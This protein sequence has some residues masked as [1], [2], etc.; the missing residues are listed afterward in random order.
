MDADARRRGDAA[1]WGAR[2]AVGERWNRSRGSRPRTGRNE[3]GYN[4]GGPPRCGGEGD[5][6]GPGSSGRLRTRKPPALIL[7]RRSA[8]SGNGRPS[9]RMTFRLLANGRLSALGV[10]RLGFCRQLACRRSA[11]GALASELPTANRQMHPSGTSRRFSRCEVTRQRRNRRPA[12]SGNGGLP[13]I[14]RRMR[15]SPPPCSCRRTSGKRRSSHRSRFT[16]RGRSDTG[17]R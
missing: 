12:K 17:Q 8:W 11:T 6:Y 4:G 7:K 10:V 13:E 16:A 15:E 14:A 1:V 3:A 5:T 2:E 9:D